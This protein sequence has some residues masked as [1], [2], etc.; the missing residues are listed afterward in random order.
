MIKM[1][2]CWLL[3]VSGLHG[4]QSDVL[5]DSGSFGSIQ[6][7]PMTTTRAPIK[8]MGGT[9]L[10]V[11]SPSP[12]DIAIL[13]P[14]N[15]RISS[16]SASSFGF[17]FETQASTPTTGGVPFGP[18]Y[19]TLVQFPQSVAAGN[20]RLELTS[21]ASEAFEARYMLQD[22]SPIRFQLLT[23]DDSFLEDQDAVVSGALFD[24]DTPITGAQVTAEMEC[25]RDVASLVQ[26]V[27]WVP[28]SSTLDGDFRVFRAQLQVKSM[29]LANLNDILLSLSGNSFNLTAVPA[30]FKIAQLAPGETWTSPEIVVRQPKGAFLPDFFQ[31]AEARGE[32]RSFTLLDSGDNIADAVA[33]DGLYGVKLRIANP[34]LCTFTGTAT[35]SSSGVAFDRSAY[36][37]FPVMPFN[38][39]LG[40]IEDYSVDADSDG[41]PEIVGVSARVNIRKDGT[42]RLDGRLAKGQK[43]F[44]LSTTQTLARGPQTMILQVTAEDLRLNVAES[45][46]FK[47]DD[48]RLS[49]VDTPVAE[50][51][52]KKL[53]AGQTAAWQLGGTAV[54]V[55][56]DGTARLAASPLPLPATG[57]TGL[58][59]SIP[60]KVLRAG[61]CSW[62]VRIVNRAGT[63]E[64]TFDEYFR[65]SGSL[66]YSY[67]LT[68]TIPGWKLRREQAGGIFEINRASV[69][70]GGPLA[71]WAGESLARSEAYRAADFENLT[72]SFELAFE[73]ADAYRLNMVRALSTIN[74]FF[75][76]VQP[77][78]GFDNNLACAASPSY[79][80]VALS[81]D[82]LP[83]RPEDWPVKISV[84]VTP[85]A[86]SGPSPVTI[87]CTGRGVTK[88]AV[89]SLVVQ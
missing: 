8:P 49:R 36:Q 71:S 30:A 73:G 19:I 89:L 40:A 85:D 51:V 56:L 52:D 24:G 16:A 15:Q 3:A 77:I 35:G 84:T 58:S 80:G 38:G 54:G 62:Q 78:A 11:N 47:R 57:Y 81:F 41:R 22:T 17:A 75:F 32:R 64:F 39:S 6:V 13:N 69:N 31:R 37:T 45:G 76:N 66:P 88:T 1:I 10:I 28:L 5:L 59:F 87:S 26:T 46:P 33:G 21:S 74:E 86:T 12:V 7:R 9:M 68:G 83:S 65:T 44:D 29:A 50:F 14:S 63:F 2:L 72:P 23:K 34:G 43:Y 60:V 25:R 53:T 4:E 79:P 82:R 18:G 42:Y 61:S 55:A 67:V 70:C 48:F 20:W 27:A